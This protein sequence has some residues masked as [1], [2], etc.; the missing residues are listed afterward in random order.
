LPEPISIQ[1][2][3][4]KQ[5]VERPEQPKTG[6]VKYSI[7]L[8]ANVKVE[9]DLKPDYPETKSLRG[10]K[11]KT[12]AENQQKVAPILVKE[13]VLPD[14]K[15][16]PT[17]EA[18]DRRSNSKDLKRTPDQA[19]PKNLKRKFDTI[20]KE[21]TPEPMT[22]RYIYCIKLIFLC[23]LTLRRLDNYPKMSHFV[24]LKCLIMTIY[25]F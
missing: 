12:V 11:R 22:K 8:K 17:V 19:D 10:R 5:V 3:V 20:E 24:I 18:V 6:E 23:S 15:P 16:D 21:K 2:D 13:K 9:P 4:I 14:S 7:G 25:F 1:N